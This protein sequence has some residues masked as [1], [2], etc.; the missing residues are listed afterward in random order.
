MKK[1]IICV[2]AVACCWTTLP[3][4]ANAA[5]ELERVSAVIEL[6]DADIAS[7]RQSGYL[8]MAIP[9]NLRNRMA[10]V[11]LKRPVNF[12]DDS[13]IVFNDVQRRSST[14]EIRVD[15]SIIDQ[16]DYQ[17]VEL[18]IYESG[19]ASILVHYRPGNTKPKVKI[20]K[21]DSPVFITR[22]SNNKSLTGHLAAMRKFTIKTALGKVDVDLNKV[23][24]IT[25]EPDNRA[26]V[27]MENGNQVSGKI[28]FKNVTVKSRW[29]LEY[30]AIKN[31]ATLTKPN[32]NPIAQPGW[33]DPAFAGNLQPGLGLPLN[34]QPATGHLLEPF[35]AEALPLP[36]P[37][38]PAMV[39]S[40]LQ[41][42]TY[43]I[44][45]AYDAFGQRIDNIP[46][47]VQQPYV[48][49]EVVNEPYPQQQYFDQAIDSLM[50]PVDP[51][52]LPIDMLLPQDLG[53]GPFLGEPYPAQAYPLP[54]EVIGQPAGL[55]IESIPNQFNGLGT[56]L[57]QPQGSI[58]N[59][60]D[61]W[62]FPQ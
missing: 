48:S 49:N 7:L 23:A 37:F 12:K 16:I 43:P 25:F 32:R 52:M 40:P 27:L 29:G 35:P 60:N 13:A 46:H 8:K 56:Q 41:N 28:D 9:R 19:V 22:M 3:A 14:I 36:Q 17:P 58:P 47:S 2:L 57:P 11:I 53:I 44:E 18:K 10:S 45:N 59:G 20:T 30:L 6:Q 33:T 26:L 42:F 54:N 31:I 15:D 39:H 1:M 24:E 21:R 61:F 51:S 62:F 38:T 34:G 4:P 50:Q 55:P 5:T